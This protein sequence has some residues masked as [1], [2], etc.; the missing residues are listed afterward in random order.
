MSWKKQFREIRKFSMKTSYREIPQNYG[1]TKFANICYREIFRKGAI[2]LPANVFKM[3]FTKI[4]SCENV[5]PRKFL[6]AK[7][8][9]FK[10]ECIM[11]QL[12]I[13]SYYLNG[14]NF[15][16][17]KISRISRMA[18]E[19]TNTFRGKKFSRMKHFFGQFSLFLCQFGR[20]VS[21]LKIS[22][23]EIFAGDKWTH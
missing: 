12:T 15:R 20:F 3:S 8:R 13:L 19:D 4:N 1:H 11:C 10:V 21:I 18:M 23:E 5:F 2:W 17:H 7:I 22:P 16:G 6:T 14:I 9:D